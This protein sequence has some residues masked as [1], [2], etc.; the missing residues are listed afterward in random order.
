MLSARDQRIHA[1]NLV[2]D[3]INLPLLRL[4]NVVCLERLRTSLS[5]RFQTTANAVV[6][7]PALRQSIGIALLQNTKT[8][9]NIGKWNESVH[10]RRSLSNIETYIHAK[11]VLRFDAA[12]IWACLCASTRG[13]NYQDYSRKLNISSYSCHTPENVHWVCH[14]FVNQIVQRCSRHFDSPAIKACW[15]LPWLLRTLTTV[16]LAHPVGPCGW[17]SF[18]FNRTTGLARQACGF[19]LAHGSFVRT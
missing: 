10:K 2:V 11:S 17:D 9:V 15:R 5:F 19:L 6:V 4:Q 8:L 13:R 16:A 14:H 7:F 12:Q 1:C 18:H 3:N